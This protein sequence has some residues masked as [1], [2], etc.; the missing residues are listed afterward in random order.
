[1]REEVYKTLLKL[2]NDDKGSIGQLQDLISKNNEEDLCLTIKDYQRDQG[3]SHFI[4]LDLS[5]T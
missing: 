1:M 5:S 3:L 2:A 4:H